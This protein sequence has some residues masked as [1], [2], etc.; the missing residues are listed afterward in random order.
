MKKQFLT[1]LA[2]LLFALPFAFSQEEGNTE[3]P[4]LEK[5]EDLF[6]SSSG[7]VIFS[8]ADL[9]VFGGE[10]GNIMRF[11][12][13][14]NLQT[15]L[16]YD[17]HSNVG[18]FAG[19]AIRNVG[20][21]FDIP[22]TDT[23]KKYRTYNLGIPLG[24]K[25][26]KLDKAFIYGGYEFEFPFNYKEKT[27][28][29][30]EKEDKFNAWFSDRVPPVQQSV[31]VGIQLPWAFNLKFKYYLTEFFNQDF[32]ETVNGMEVMPYNGVRANVFYIALTTNPFKKSGFKWD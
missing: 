6:I 13:V 27:F 28:I 5:K 12:P 26:G 17:P 29:D 10:E 25:L 21:I 19:L 32:T 16:N 3:V 11:S 9:D 31:F 1:L 8:F 2:M 22:G 18:M 23:R 4:K 20:F 15:F 30:G 24:L 14:F 7:E